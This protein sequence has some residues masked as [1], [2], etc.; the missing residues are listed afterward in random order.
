MAVAIY[1]NS[2]LVKGYQ[3]GPN[4]P[5]ENI[6]S[7]QVSVYGVVCVKVVETFGHIQ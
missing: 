2:G 3:G 7:I 5:N 1:E 4:R 6:Y